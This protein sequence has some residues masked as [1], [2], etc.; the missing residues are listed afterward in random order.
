MNTTTRYIQLFFT[1][2]AI[3]LTGF[4]LQAKN[5][6]AS[7]DFVVVIDA[8]HG[9]HDTGAV[10]NG[11]KEKEINLGVS[12]K[13]GE[14]IKKNMKGVKVVY[15]RS[16]DTFKS[17]QERADI[18]NNAK[19]NLFI[20]IHTNSVDKSNRNRTT[21]AGASVYAL[22]LHKDEN[23]MRVARRENAVIQLESNYE[24]KY[25]GFDPDKDESYIIFEMAQKK[26]LSKSIRFAHD[27]QKQLVSTADR[28]DRG[29]HQA[30]FWVLWATSM[31][32]VLVE[33]DFICNPNSANFIT[34][35]EGQTKM[36]KAIFNAFKNYEQRER[37]ISGQPI[38]PQQAEDLEEPG[39]STEAL[40]A[41]NVQ[42]GKSGVRTH[43]T[44]NSSRKS[45]PAKRR[46]R[47][48]QAKQLSDSR[49]VET[50]SIPLHSDDEW[51]AAAEEKQEEKIEE[52]APQTPEKKGK[53]AKTAKKKEE[54]S[55]RDKS[56]H[57][58]KVEKF[59]TV[60]SIQILASS[61]K[62]RPSDPRFHGLSPISMF[63]ENNLYK[64]TYGTKESKAEIE[65]LLKKIRKD[66]PDA[67]VIES[68]RNAR[69]SN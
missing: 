40:L 10:D 53:K 50:A 51:I 36:A 28:K 63:R 69:P 39:N 16:D 64:Y 67:F 6:A 4:S 52:P 3:M 23:N 60:Y 37:L 35:E 34:S 54:K 68:R 26:N 20:S 14:M 30:G 25:Q 15:T 46:R 38:R 27:V 59:Q 29:V 49:E 8:G 65:S 58:S 7:D 18:A 45:V 19:G 55:N 44:D 47:N 41:S 21:V 9:G 5:A 13:L 43:N 12:L 32:A 11:G 2:L 57:K 48:L 17:L 62:L 42:S 31:P 61:D 56:R 33:L 1:L 66:F 22:G 24:K